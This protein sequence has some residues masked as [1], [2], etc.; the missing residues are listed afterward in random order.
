MK[1]LYINPSTNDIEFN[2]SNSLKMVDG[3]DA[4]MQ[5]IRIILRT[6]LGEWFL[7][8]ESGFARFNI[9]GHKFDEEQAVEEVYA[10]ILQ[11]TEVQSVEN[12][13]AEFDRPNRKIIINYEVVRINGALVQGVETI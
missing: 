5:G 13:T 10:A 7:N 9:L 6:N 2:G 3:D 8:L 12:V 1:T 11:N 4:F